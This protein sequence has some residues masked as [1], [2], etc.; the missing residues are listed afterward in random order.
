MDPRNTHP[1]FGFI[2]VTFYETAVFFVVEIF[3]KGNLVKGSFARKSF[4][5]EG[6]LINFSPS[7]KDVFCQMFG[8]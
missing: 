6:F 4:L 3:E 1:K 5:V 7:L 8:I 2:S